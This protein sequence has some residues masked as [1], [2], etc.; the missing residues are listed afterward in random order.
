MAT[1]LLTARMVDTAKSEKE[2]FLSDGG[3]L[4]LRIRPGADGSKCTKHWFYRYTDSAKRRR[5]IMLGAYPTHSLNDARRWAKEQTR[6]LDIGTDPVEAKREAKAVSAEK[7]R[8]TCGSLLDAYAAHLKAQGKQSYDDVTNIFKLHV[9]DAVKG[10]PASRVT[11]SD[12]ML[13]IR[14]LVEVKKDRTAAKLRSYL[15]AAF[16]LALNANDDPNAPSSMIGFKLQTNPAARIK[17]P[18][19]S[20]I[21]GERVLSKQELLDYA[22]HLEALPASDTRDI[23]CLQLLL[24]GQRVSQLLQ[25]T[26]EGNNIVQRDTKGKRLTARRHIIPLQGKAA[27]LVNAR[28]KLFDLRSKDNP[29]KPSPRL[30][31]IRASLAVRKISAKMSGQPFRL[32]DIRRT[33]ETML[34][35][36]GFGSD[37][38]GQLLSHGLGGVQNRHYDKHDYLPEKMKMLKAWEELLTQTPATNV[39]FIKSQSG[40][41]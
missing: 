22:L 28:G 12:L 37:L 5:K 31:L 14:K 34:A 36:M 1:H 38:R 9:S 23:L 4:L 16:E 32:G 17:V 8:N 10:M 27:S 35:A 33:A 25:A 3:N 19:G 11:H 41:I 40:Q 2:T 20:N 13:L 15:R 21:P 7:I 39:V 24:A 26:L 6:L 30:A 29:D 18:K